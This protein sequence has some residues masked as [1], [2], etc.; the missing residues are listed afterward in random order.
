MK[1]SKK[2]L[3]EL[4]SFLSERNATEWPP[5]FVALIVGPPLSLQ[6][7]TYVLWFGLHYLLV[8]PFAFTIYISVKLQRK[9]FRLFEF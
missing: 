9:H 4:L 3:H 2:P 8:Y 5:L 1:Q 7:T 6:Y